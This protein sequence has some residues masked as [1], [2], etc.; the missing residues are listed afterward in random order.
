[1]KKKTHAINDQQGFTIVEIIVGLLVLPLFLYS[2][3]LVINSTGS[4]NDQSKDFTLANGIAEEK[5]EALRSADFIGLPVGGTV[6]DFESELP[7]SL[8]PPRVAEYTVTDINVSLKQIDVLIEYQVGTR[9][10]SLNYSSFIGEL[11]VGQ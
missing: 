5:V 1:M 9:T 4:L 8:K 7:A 10:Q 11:G 3:G 6:V 2:I